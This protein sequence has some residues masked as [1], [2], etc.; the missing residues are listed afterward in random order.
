MT[1]APE[2]EM[3]TWTLPRALVWVLLIRFLSDGIIG[4]IH[5]FRG[6]DR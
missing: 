5:L 3:K 4:W 1:D 2:K 6:P